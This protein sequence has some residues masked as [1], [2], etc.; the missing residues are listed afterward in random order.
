ML[1]SSLV[2]RQNFDAY[3]WVV[4]ERRSLCSFSIWS[5]LFSYHLKWEKDRKRKTLK[6]TKTWNQSFC[7]LKITETLICESQHFGS[8]KPNWKTSLKHWK[9]IPSM[10]LQCF[11]TASWVFLQF[12]YKIHLFFRILSWVSVVNPFQPSVAFHIET[13]HLIWNPDEI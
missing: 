4:Y 3:R 2:I 6:N 8:Y 1:C 5:T 11:K 9:V 12:P 10:S 13:N 7:D